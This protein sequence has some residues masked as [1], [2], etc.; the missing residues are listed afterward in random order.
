[1]RACYAGLNHSDN[2]PTAEVAVPV[3]MMP[4][5]SPAA[6]A[7]TPVVADSVPIWLVAA[8]PATLIKKPQRA[9]FQCSKSASTASITILTY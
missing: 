8:V 5:E 4:S 1:M 6:R 7:V 2:A 3:M 9:A